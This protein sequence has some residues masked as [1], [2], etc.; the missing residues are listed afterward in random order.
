MLGISF[1]RLKQLQQAAKLPL[2]PR[3]AGYRRRSWTHAEAS[4]I[5]AQR[6]AALAQMPRNGRARSK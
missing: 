6:F 1:T 5:V 3:V 4:R 2:P